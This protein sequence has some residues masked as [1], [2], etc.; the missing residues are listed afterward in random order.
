MVFYL[1]LNESEYTWLRVLTLQVE[2]GVNLGFTFTFYI[3]VK[4]VLDMFWCYVLGKN[5]EYERS[6]E[7]DLN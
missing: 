6:T 1:E 5:I 4:T 7:T 2:C 3:F